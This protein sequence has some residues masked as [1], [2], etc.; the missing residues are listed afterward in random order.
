MKII[1]SRNAWHKSNQTIQFS[2]R[3]LKGN[4]KHEQFK[5]VEMKTNRKQD[6]TKIAI[7]MTTV[8]IETNPKP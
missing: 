6:A 4:L 8:K 7:M 5:E 3:L 1:M 2:Q